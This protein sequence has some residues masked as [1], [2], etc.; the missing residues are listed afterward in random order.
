MGM[1]GNE[2]VKGGGGAASRGC[3]VGRA[4]GCKRGIKNMKVS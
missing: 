2:E 1:R 4:L 3:D